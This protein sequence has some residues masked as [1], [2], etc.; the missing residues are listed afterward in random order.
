MKRNEIKTARWY[1]I[2]ALD[3]IKAKEV[4][5]TVVREQGYTSIE[6]VEVPLK[7]VNKRNSKRI[8]RDHPLFSK[9]VYVKGNLE[10]IVNLVN[11]NKA[12]IIGRVV[13]QTSTFDTRTSSYEYFA[14]PIPNVE[15]DRFFY[16]C[17]AVQEIT[18]KKQFSFLDIDEEELF[19]KGRKARIV[20]GPL[21]GY[22]VTI[23]STSDYDTVEN[24]TDS[25]VIDTKSTVKLFDEVTVTKVFKK[26]TIL[27]RMFDG[28][29]EE[30]KLNDVVVEDYGRENGEATFQGLPA[31]LTDVKLQALRNTERYAVLDSFYAEIDNLLELHKAAK[32][33][34]LTSSIVTKKAFAY[35]KTSKQAN[36]DYAHTT[37]NLWSRYSVMQMLCYYLL[38]N[39]ESM[40]YWL[41]ICDELLLTSAQYDKKHAD[42]KPKHPVSASKKTKKLRHLELKNEAAKLFQAKY[43]YVCDMT[44]QRRQAITRTT[45]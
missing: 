14:P 34:G 5:E 35:L 45:E 28:T 21:D 15:I 11:R 38:D 9:Y 27:I 12:D 22:E 8:V 40:K 7:Y 3:C 4:I 33:A 24:E 23:V 41:N 16:L 36:F 13:G 1:V 42:D 17:D 25:D 19:A 20:G 10:E 6:R 44:E 37:A 31:E 32:E 26:A 18:G 29:S 2:S 39:S 43:C 30:V